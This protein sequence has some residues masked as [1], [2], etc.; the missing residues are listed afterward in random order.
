[1]VLFAE[2]LWP[3]LMGVLAVAVVF[4][5]VTI[6]GLWALLPWLTHY[7]LL[8]VFAGLFAFFLI[9][10]LNDLEFPT[11]RDALR[12]LQQ[13]GQVRHSALLAI[14]DRPFNSLD[15]DNPLWQKYQAD[16]RRAAKQARL[17]KAHATID[18]RDP[19]ALRYGAVLLLVVGLFITK[20][21][22]GH[23]FWQAFHPGAGNNSL[24]T[25]DIWIDP[26]DYTGEQAVVLVNSTTPITKDLQSEK[27]I[28]VPAGS[29]LE[30]RLSGAPRHGPGAPALYLMDAEGRQKI[31]LTRDKS[32]VQTSTPLFELGTLIL[33]TGHK[34]MRWPIEIREDRAPIVLW[35]EDPATEKGG[36]KLTVEIAD[37]YG[38]AEAFAVIRLDPDQQRHPDLAPVSDSVLRKTERLPLSR[39]RGKEGTRAQILN[40]EALPWAGLIAQIRIEVIDGGGNV[41]STSTKSVKLPTRTFYNPLAQAIAHER[42]ELAVAPHR[43]PNTGRA[44]DALTIAPDKFFDDTT[45]YLLLRTAYWDVMHKRGSEVED[46]VDKLWPLAL[47]LEDKELELARRA[48]DAARQALREALERGASEDEINRLIEELRMAMNNY[49]TALANS[50]QAELAQGEQSQS[51]DGRDL[52]D[53]L[54]EM[55]DLSRSGANN[56]ARQLLSELEQMLENLR[57]DPNGS[58]G[59]ASGQGSGQG[60]GQGSGQG[61]GDPALQAAGDLIAKQRQLTDDTWSSARNARNGEP[62]GRSPSDLAREQEKLREDLNKFKNALGAAGNNDAARQA[63]RDFS[64]ALERMEEAGDA[65]EAGRTGTAAEIQSEALDSMRRGASALAEAR[66]NQPGQEQQGQAQNGGQQGFQGQAL[67]PLGRPYSSDENGSEAL[68]PDFSDP[69]RARE[70]I[71]ELRRRLSEPGRS[72]EEIDYLERL[73]ERF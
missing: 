65:L 13:D 33:K 48:L 10:D 31:P 35:R 36:L 28:S 9:R 11:R 56:A 21:Q 42:R 50:G 73:L 54:D 3:R 53:L 24:L 51:L 30:L 18:R 1:M 19:F 49:I 32:L 38:I 64:D 15:E 58:G 47:Q 45:D 6:A 5:L 12:R 72:K 55:R 52:E 60:Q 62:G 57:I 66:Q 43:W 63:Q 7:A 26:P 46:T 4:V 8:G 20:G 67:D 37:D 39:I 41:E 29:I 68:I 2:E 59:Q 69:E 44:L 61:K 14:E 27:T 71:K 23:L 17:G 16:M 22:T 25:A 70:L 40:T 34:T